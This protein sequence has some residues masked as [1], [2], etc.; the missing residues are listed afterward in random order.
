LA[1]Q[2]ALAALT[3][4]KGV[5]FFAAFLPQFIDP[6][7]SLWLQ[8]AVMA[9]TFVVVESITE[10]VIAATAA[11]VRP[12]LN[13]VGRRFNQ[14]CGGLFMLIGAALPFRG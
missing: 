14:V 11:R 1:W 6:G 4:P 13:R 2:G 8:F 10:L 5:L 9:G 3:N 7:R 12:W